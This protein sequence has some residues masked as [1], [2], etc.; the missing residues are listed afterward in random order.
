[1][2]SA[3]AAPSPVVKAICNIVGIDH[4]QDHPLARRQQLYARQ[5]GRS[6]CQLPELQLERDRRRAMQRWSPQRKRERP[7]LLFM[8]G[9]RTQMA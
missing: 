8:S 9:S 2:A 4:R 5:R 3:A 7:T 6:R 1:M